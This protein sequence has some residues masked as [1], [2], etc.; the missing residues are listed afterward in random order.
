MLGQ[1]QTLLLIRLRHFAPGIFEGFGHRHAAVPVPVGCLGGERLHK[2]LWKLGFVAFAAGLGR[3]DDRTARTGERLQKG[4]ACAGRVDEDEALGREPV[5]QLC[6]LLGR[7]VGARQVERCFSTVE[8]AVSEEHHEDLIMGPHAG[9]QIREC[10]FDVFAG[11]TVL[12]PLRVGVGFLRKV[13]NVALGN[14]VLPSRRVDEHRRPLMKFL[15]VL[16]VARDT[17]DDDEVGFLGGE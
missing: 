10:S 15:A 1:Q 2:I 4:A 8:A 13:N 6:V 14:A 9:G 5:E 3:R 12:D 11:G 17:G 16:L 7:K